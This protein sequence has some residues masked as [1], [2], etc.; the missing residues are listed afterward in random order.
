MR[1]ASYL[2]NGQP[3]AAVLASDQTLVPVSQLVSGAPQTM[4]ELLEGGPALWDRVREAVSNARGGQ[5]VSQATLLA[6]IPR[7]RRNVFCV[8]WNYSEHFAEG[9]GMRGPGDSPA[10]IPE[11]PA[12]FSKQ[13]NTVIGAAAPVWHPAPVSDQLDWEVELAVIVGTAG[14]DIAEEGA[15][16]HVFGYTVANDVSVRDVQRRHG[17]QW[18][19]GKNFDTHCPLGPWIVTADEL[20]DPHNLHITLRVNGVTKQDSSTRFMVFRIPRIIKECSTGLRLEAGDVILTGTPE[21]VGFARKPPEFLKVGDVMEAEIE[22]IGILRNTVA[23]YDP[24]AA[25]IGSPTVAA[26]GR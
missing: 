20:G 10:D 23:T 9:Q 19:K 24:N 6:P 5:P 16:D 25:T 22:N 2:A 7:P 17:G 8:G 3:R 18:F 1:L 12:L 14:R 21:G 15:Y 26:A 11:Y 13:P 4:L